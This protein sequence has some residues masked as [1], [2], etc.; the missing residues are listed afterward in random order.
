MALVRMERYQDAR[1]RLRAA[2]EIHAAQPGFTHALARL[3]AA[4]PDPQARDGRQAMAL[5]QA[6][7]EAQ[8]R[9]DLGETMAMVLAEVG[10]YE[11]AAAWQR[12]A[13]AAARGKGDRGLAQRMEGNLR[14]YDARR[15]CRTPWRAEDQP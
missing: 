12:D 8:R 2:L 11:Q 13:I 3:L 6:L 4:A 15:P 14:L 9:L 5:M 1:D 10:E 7:P